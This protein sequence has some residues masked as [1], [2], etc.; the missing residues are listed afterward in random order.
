[1]TTSAAVV[2]IGSLLIYWRNLPPETPLLYSRPWGQDQLVSPYF[3]WILPFVS[4]GV[5]VVTGV[6]GQKICAEGVLRSMLL[7]TSLVIQVITITGLI[8]I[9]LLVT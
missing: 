1:M 8:R 4:S 7:T 5:G 3:L 9:L 6:W 2:G